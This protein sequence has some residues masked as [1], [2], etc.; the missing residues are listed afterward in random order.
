M[1]FDTLEGIDIQKSRRIASEKAREEGRTEGHAEGREEG[2][3]E[4][5]EEGHAEGR[6]EVARNL[7]KMN[8]PV[9]VITKATGLSANEI[10]KL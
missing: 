4:G 1:H 10:E 7:K 6:T 8:T 3:A 5:R 9:D 2:H